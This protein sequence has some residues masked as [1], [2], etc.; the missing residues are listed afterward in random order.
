MKSEAVEGIDDS[1]PFCDR[2][3]LVA[4]CEA[5]RGQL[6]WLA[7]GFEAGGRVIVISE[8]CGRVVLGLRSQHDL[9]HLLPGA[10][11]DGEGEG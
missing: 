9:N 2:L 11:T 10:S 4:E 8:H 6:A 7:M 3:T 5:D 1:G